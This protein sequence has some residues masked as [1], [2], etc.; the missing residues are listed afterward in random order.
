MVVRE[1]VVD[2]FD[3]EVDVE[4]DVFG[5]EVTVDDVQTVEVLYSVQNL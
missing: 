2:K 5:F 1:T 3:V 4:E